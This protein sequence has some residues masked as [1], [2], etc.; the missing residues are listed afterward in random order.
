[1]LWA[2]LFLF[3]A[4]ELRL[5]LAL[6]ES[7]TDPWINLQPSQVIRKGICSVSK[8]SGCLE[9]S[10]VKLPGKQST[11]WLSWLAPSLCKVVPQYKH[12]STSCISTLFY[13]QTHKQM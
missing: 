4:L 9:V 2:L 1:M 3:K 5:L 6:I 13:C 7:S 11:S 12:A 10:S 8:P